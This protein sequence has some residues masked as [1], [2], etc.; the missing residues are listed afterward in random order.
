[1]MKRFFNITETYF[2]IASILLLLFIFETTLFA[3]DDPAKSFGLVIPEEVIDY[4][5]TH[6]PDPIEFNSNA[7]PT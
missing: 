2:L 4:W 7:F 6:L 1:M 5:N 3:E